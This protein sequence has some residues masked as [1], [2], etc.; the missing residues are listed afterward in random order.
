MNVLILDNYDSFT[1]NL[2]H[3]FK[4]LVSSVSVFRNDESSIA[5]IEKYSHIVISPGPG[6]PKDAGVLMD[7][8]SQ[9]SESKKILGVC[10]G[11]QAIAEHFGGELYNQ[12]IVKHGLQEEIEITENRNGLFKGI[13]NTTHVGLYHSWAVNPNNLPSCFNIT[14]KG[15]TGVTMAIE[16]KTLPISG[17]QFHPESIMTTE[18]K[19]M[20]K[21]WLEA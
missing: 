5:E 7:A 8:L 17:V 12:E 13:A 14:A 9:Y 16:H 2:F 6:L 19:T 15:K 4:G 1:Y 3:Y 18:G 20:I 21:N 11:M 10:L